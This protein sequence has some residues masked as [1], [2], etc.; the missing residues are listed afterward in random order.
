MYDVLA[1][2][3]MLIDF[4]P[5]ARGVGLADV[6][7][8]EKKPG[9]APANVAVGVA[10]LGGHAAFLGKFGDDPFGD[11]LLGTLQQFGVDTN[12]CRKTQE[13]KTGLAFIAVDERGEHE[14]HFYRDPSADMLLR[15]EDIRE[16]WIQNARIVHVGSVTQFLPEAAAATRKALKLARQH[17]VITSF[18]VNFRLGIWRGREAEGKQKILDTIQLTDVLKVSESEMVFLTGTEDVE[19]GAQM[20]LEM[21]PKIVFVTLGDQGVYYCTSKHR[22]RVPSFRVQAVDVTGAGDAFVAG[23]LRQLAD[24]IQGRGIDYSLSMHEEI[25]EMTRYGAA[26]GALTVTKMGAIP[27]LPTKEEVFQ[28]MYRGAKRNPLRI[29]T[30]E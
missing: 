2:G 10:K 17:G 26:V 21:G 12:G 29:P 18:D 1:I 6:P 23:F 20:L 7:A 5:S 30:Q 15:E 27:A 25:E 19:R 16:E 22:R 14:F 13:A 9:G 24:R 8:F 3:E 28:F 4:T 11:F